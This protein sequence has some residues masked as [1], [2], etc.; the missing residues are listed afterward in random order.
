MMRQLL[1][2]S[3]AQHA[4]QWWL[5][6]PSHHQYLLNATAFLFCPFVIANRLSGGVA[7]FLSSLRDSSTIEAIYLLNRQLH[8]F[9]CIIFT[10]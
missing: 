7:I 3:N 2:H 10:K 6:S 4:L 8:V 9:Y 1:G 5:Y